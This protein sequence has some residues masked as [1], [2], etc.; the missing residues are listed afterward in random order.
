MNFD[1]IV[2][3]KTSKITLLKN[4]VNIINHHLNIQNK[5][6]F[7][8]RLDSILLRVWCTTGHHTP[9]IFTAQITLFGNLQGYHVGTICKSS[10][11]NNFSTRIK[12]HFFNIFEKLLCLM[13]FTNQHILT[14]EPNVIT[15][16]H[17]LSLLEVKFLHLAYILIWIKKYRLYLKFTYIF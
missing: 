9:K 10:I 3:M 5:Q 17:I 13:G 14:L 1:L 16:R 15:L 4:K 2:Y 6:I 11:A 12:F 7:Y 8:C